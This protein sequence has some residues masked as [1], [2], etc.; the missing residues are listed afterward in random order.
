[1]SLDG[2]Y[3]RLIES[4]PEH[5]KVEAVKQNANVLVYIKNPSLRILRVALDKEISA[6]KNVMKYHGNSIS[7][8]LLSK[9]V[10]LYPDVLKYIPQE[11]MTEELKK[12][13]LKKDIS[14]IQYI[15]TQT[16]E[17]HRV[18]VKNLNTKNA[19]SILYLKDLGLS[20]IEAIDKINNQLLTLINEKHNPR[21]AEYTGN[22]GP[23]RKAKNAVAYYFWKMFSGKTTLGEDPIKNVKKIENISI[24]DIM[25]FVKKHNAKIGLV[26][27]A[28]GPRVIS[29]IRSPARDPVSTQRGLR[30]LT[31]GRR[32]AQPVVG[33]R[34]AVR[35]LGV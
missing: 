1:V 34:I 23:I 18:F 17:D 5:V 31:I 16:H 8:T 2:R 28:A 14:S 25:N 26:D 21:L 20:M 27:Q 9:V 29:G 15:K 12:K 10:S 33:E 19:Y 35:D 7:N 30:A 11:R 6:M 13:A 32:A 22:L 4:P 3:I 24:N